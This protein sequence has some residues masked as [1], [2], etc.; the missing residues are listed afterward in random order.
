VT[1]AEWLACTD[2]TPML[3]HLGDRATDR[4]LRLFAVACCRRI[5]PQM[6]DRR[7]RRAVTLAERSAD[8]S[9]SYTEL[10]AASGEA[11]EAF[12]DSFCTGGKAVADKDQRPDAAEA[13]TC[14]SSPGRLGLEDFSVVL[15]R[16]QAAS[17]LGAAQER[18]AQAALLRCIFGPAL[19]RPLPPVAPA[20]L[21]WGGGTVARLADAV[22]QERGFTP[23]R[24]GVLAD[25]AE[26]AGVTDAD[27]LG[28]LRGPG[29]HVRGC[30]A[31]D[32]LL[33]KG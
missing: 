19:F 7:S 32:L 14:V 6:A 30:W 28:H 2:P 27:L 33:G 11:G 15:E 20:V 23:G 31:V 21:A 8:E 13:A 24:M 1:E 22:Y 17:L 4:K 26:E 10:D 29:P 16:G 25:A 18:S 5:W 12:L 9:V 3:E